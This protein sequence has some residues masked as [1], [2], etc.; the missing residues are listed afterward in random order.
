MRFLYERNRKSYLL[1]HNSVDVQTYICI[2]WQHPHK[3]ILEKKTWC[4]TTLRIMF[5][6]ITKS[7]TSQ[8]EMMNVCAAITHIPVEMFSTV[9]I[10]WKCHKYISSPIDESFGHHIIMCTILR[11]VYVYGSFCNT[12]ETKYIQCNVIEVSIVITLRKEIESTWRSDVYIR[13]KHFFTKKEKK[14]H[15]NVLLGFNDYHH[16]IYWLHADYYF[17]ALAFL[18]PTPI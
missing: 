11:H 7:N 16:F 5:A 13:Y 9:Q 2:E 15:W 6:N 8:M 14:I 4:F 12:S 17:K 1:V 10:A 3:W 18:W